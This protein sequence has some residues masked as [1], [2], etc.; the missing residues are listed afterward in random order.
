M[1][2]GS[3]LDKSIRNAFTVNS[4][5]PARKPC[6]TCRV[7]LASVRAD[8]TNISPRPPFQS[9]LALPS[10]LN[11]SLRKDAVSSHVAVLLSSA[12]LGRHLAACWAGGTQ[13][14]RDGNR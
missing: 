2:N 11:M 14:R 1:D 8:D 12:I 7:H 10:A 9:I 4:L 3:T 13:A 5:L 6:V